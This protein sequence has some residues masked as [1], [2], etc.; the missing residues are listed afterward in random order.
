MRRGCG[1]PW[2][3]VMPCGLAGEQLRGEVAERAHH[4]RA[5]QLDLCEEVPLAGLDLLGLRVAVPGRAAL[6]HVGDV[7]VGRARARS[8]GAAARAPSRPGRRTARPACPRGSR[9]P[10]RRTSGRRPGGPSRPRPGC[11]R[12][13][14]RTWHSLATRPPVARALP[15]VRV[16]RSRIAFWQAARTTPVQWP[17]PQLPPQQPPP[18]PPTVAPTGRGVANDDRSFVAR[19]RCRMRGSGQ[20]RRSDADTSSSNVSEQSAHRYS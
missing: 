12:P 9:A 10:R 8:S 4:L 14:A 18:P 11:A 16:R 19:F 1:R 5:D 2:T 20:C 13:R 7:D 3:R 15:R 17:Q 6:E